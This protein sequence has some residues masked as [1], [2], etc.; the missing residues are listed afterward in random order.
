MDLGD[1]RIFTGRGIGGIGGVCAARI[2]VKRAA[3]RDRDVFVRKRGVGRG[4]QFE[5]LFVARREKQGGILRGE[6]D[7]IFRLRRRD[8]GLCGGSRKRCAERKK[9]GENGRAFS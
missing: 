6:D 2:E 8:T 7:G 9:N 1:R 5:I 4:V 3:V